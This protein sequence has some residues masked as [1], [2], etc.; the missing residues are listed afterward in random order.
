MKTS[1][2][3]ARKRRL[4]MDRRLIETD[5]KLPFSKTP[6]NN[7]WMGRKKGLSHLYR[8]YHS[9]DGLHILWNTYNQI[10]S[11]F[12][13]DYGL[14]LLDRVDSKLWS[15]RC[16]YYGDM[17][18]FHRK[19]N[20]NN[21][22]W[23]ETSQALWTSAWDAS[24]RVWASFVYSFVGCWIFKPIIPHGNGLKYLCQLCS[25]TRLFHTCFS[26]ILLLK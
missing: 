25:V 11:C 18:Q 2:T 6:K 22:D 8:G 5:K 21:K 13:W 9:L 19:R 15:H 16:T 4:R 17:L 24:F 7:V 14:S 1:V 26:S 12:R 3:G 20:A 23:K 10:H